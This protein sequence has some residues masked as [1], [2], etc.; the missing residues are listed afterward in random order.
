MRVR[1]REKEKSSITFEAI[2]TWQWWT[3]DVSDGRARASARH[4]IDER[5]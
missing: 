4:K 2:G 1:V 3:N 5:L